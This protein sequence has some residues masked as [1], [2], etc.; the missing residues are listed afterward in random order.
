MSSKIE[1]SDSTEEE[2]QAEIHYSHQFKSGPPRE[3]RGI[4][5]KVVAVIVV[6]IVLGSAGL[7]VW[8]EYLRHWSMRDVVM[9]V[10]NDPY[11]GTP[12]FS[13]NLAGRKVVVEGEVTNI[14]T[15]QTTQGPLSFIELD[16]VHEM[17]L[18]IWGEV[19][20]KVCKRISMDVKFE[21]SIC[22]DERHVYSPQL[23]FPTYAYLPSVGLVLMSVAEVGGTVMNTT[24]QE[25]GTILVKVFDQYPAIS[26]TGMNCSLS[27][28]RASFT[29]EY[30]EVMGIGDPNYSYGHEIDI[31]EDL[32]T[33]AGRNGSLTFVDSDSD[34]YLS[35][36]DTFALKN[37]ER[38]EQESGAYT[39]ALILSF[40]DPPIGR[41]VP[42]LAI[43]YCV[44]TSKGGLEFLDIGAPYARL[45]SEI[46]SQTE[47]RFTFAVASDQTP[48]DNV[49]LLLTDRFNTERW[50]PASGDLDNGP[51][52]REE[53]PSITVGGI[54]ATCSVFDIEGDGRV[55]EGDSFS[56]ST[57]GGTSFSTNVNY[58]LTVIHEPTMERMGH[59]TFHG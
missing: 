13:H 16:D 35:R 12:G 59:S 23:D 54:S 36:N 55:E 15:Y 8:F 25:D 34:G 38:P 58:T 18:V 46:L 48:W 30:V 32:R 27:V 20:Y 9:E 51:M 21:W 52:S 49:S 37:L 6:V 3:S 19:P 17:R 26:L 7:F 44:M 56:V 5:T 50:Y 28:G 42:E 47:V 22:N 31:I 33:G 10:I 57:W 1:E 14:T 24:Q 2:A 11:V 40:V 29:A 43:W 53:L 41:T 45:E 4:S 39:Y